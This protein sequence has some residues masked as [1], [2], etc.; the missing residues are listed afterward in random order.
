MPFLL[1]AFERVGYEIDINPFEG[2]PSYWWTL[3]AGVAWF[4]VTQFETVGEGRLFPGF[5]FAYQCTCPKTSR[6]F[7]S[8]LSFRWHRCR[9]ARLSHSGV[10]CGVRFWASRFCSE[11]GA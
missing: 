4:C 5:N 2:R 10:Q 6:P 3:E 9:S 7:W 1:Q 11:P 8:V